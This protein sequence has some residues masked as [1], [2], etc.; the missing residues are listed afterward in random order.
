[1]SRVRPSGDQPAETEPASWEASGPEQAAADGPAEGHPAELDF[2]DRLAEGRALRRKV[3]RSAHAAWAP[4]ADRPDPID[5]LEASN[6]FPVCFLK[7]GPRD[8][9]TSA[10]IAIPPICSG[11]IDCGIHRGLRRRGSRR[12]TSLAARRPTSVAAARRG[13]ASPVGSTAANA[14]GRRAAS[15]HVGVRAAAGGVGGERGEVLGTGA[16]YEGPGTRG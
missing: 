5:L 3:P 1:M 16:G 8:C 13:T 14:R 7:L 6:R 9:P 11:P 2:A 10:R 12:L 4:P 15:G